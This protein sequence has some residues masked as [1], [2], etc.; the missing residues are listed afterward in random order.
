[1]GCGKR[2]GS[3]WWNESVKKVVEEK[4]K[5]YEEWMQTRIR[6][7]WEAYREKR[8]ECKRVVRRAKRDAKLR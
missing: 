1:M 6:R 3:E 5:A 4:K 7:L 2:K 8:K